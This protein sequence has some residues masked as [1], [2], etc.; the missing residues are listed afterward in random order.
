VP[1]TGPAGRAALG[2][3][4]V[5]LLA[6]TSAR[7]EGVD[8]RA[9][10]DRPGVKLVVVEFYATWCRPCM[11]AI[12]RWSRLHKRFQDRGL[13]LI[14]VNTR[15]P[16]AGCQALP[17]TPDAQVCDYEGAVEQRFGVG[18]QL[19]S[20]FLWSWQGNLLVQRG[21]VDQVQPAIEDHLR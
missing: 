19:P 12:P 2:A 4:C 7:G 18:G 13:R 6:P 15:D 3:L 10:L 17:W 21:H 1:H 9:W 8:V 16:D 5:C 20:A 14:V 11:E